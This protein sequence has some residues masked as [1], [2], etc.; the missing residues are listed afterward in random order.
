MWRNFGW[1][2]ILATWT[3]FLILNS[4]LT[5]EWIFNNQINNEY[6]SYKVH[7]GSASST[8]DRKA[9]Y[10]SK[11]NSKSNDRLSMH[12][13][14]VFSEFKN[15]ENRDL[16]LSGY[17]KRD[18]TNAKA[19]ATPSL[20]V[21]PSH[22]LKSTLRKKRRKEKTTYTFSSD[23][24]KAAKLRRDIRA[25][26]KKSE[27]HRK[28]HKRERIFSRENTKT[29]FFSD[30]F[31]KR[32]CNGSSTREFKNSDISKLK[33]IENTKFRRTDEKRE[34]NRNDEDSRQSLTK[35]GTNKLM[36]VNVEAN[37][38]SRILE[39]TFPNY[40][41]LKGNQSLG[42][43]GTVVTDNTVTKNSPYKHSVTV[44]WTTLIFNSKISKTNKGVYNE[45]NT[46]NPY[47][48]PQNEYS[49]SYKRDEF[50]ASETYKRH[51][52]S[53]IGFKVN[54]DAREDRKGNDEDIVDSFASHEPN[55]L[56]RH[57]AREGSFMEDFPLQKEKNAV[58]VAQET[59]GSRREY[60]SFI[61]NIGARI[62]RKA[63][64]LNE[65]QIRRRMREREITAGANYMT[66]NELEIKRD[67]LPTN[68]FITGISGS[69]LEYPT[70]ARISITRKRNPMHVGYVRSGSDCKHSRMTDFEAQVSSA[71]RF[72][73]WNVSGSS[74]LAK[75]DKPLDREAHSRVKYSRKFD[76]INIDARPP[77]ITKII[78]GR[79]KLDEELRRT[80]TENE[81][82][83]PSAPNIGDNL[84][85]MRVINGYEQSSSEPTDESGL[86]NVRDGNHSDM[87]E[88]SGFYSRSSGI[89]NSKYRRYKRHEVRNTLGNPTSTEL[90]SET[91][92]TFD[93]IRPTTSNV[94]IKF[95]PNPSVSVTQTT[96]TDQ[97][98]N[99][100]FLT[101]VKTL[102]SSGYRKI[103]KKWQSI[104]SMTTD[105]EVQHTNAS[106]GIGSNGSDSLETM[107]VDIPKTFNVSSIDTSAFL[108]KTLDRSTAIN[109]TDNS[110]ILK[111][112]SST[113]E[114]NLQISY[115]TNENVFDTSLIE[116][117]NSQEDYGMH[118]N[119][120]IVD[121]TI[122]PF[123][124]RSIN[125]PRN[126]LEDM[127]I[128]NVDDSS[129]DDALSD[130]W[131][132]KHSAVVEGDLVLGGLMMVHEREDTITCGPVMPQG[133][134]QALEAMLYTLDKL[135]D[136]EIV[137]GV[138]I[139]AHI[140]DDC[141]KDTYGLEMAV[142]FIKA[143]LDF[144]DHPSR[145]E[146][147]ATSDGHSRV[148]VFNCTKPWESLS[149]C[150]RTSAHLQFLDHATWRFVTE[151]FKLA[152]CTI[153]PAGSKLERRIKIFDSGRRKSAGVE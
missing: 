87:R 109:K 23:R 10:D 34:Y 30:K 128:E 45:E 56:D 38:E 147:F 12:M 41:S 146:K 46:I 124:Q 9:I 2:A 96:N 83:F 89:H 77:H 145:S 101:T 62:N 7:Q 24:K 106:A 67:L 118:G 120:T 115:A 31:R 47:H 129:T 103:S 29:A 80:S 58:K 82:I 28:K 130:Q 72:G 121:P 110:V 16:R 66:R 113:P 73:L 135:N 40:S 143:D 95:T 122:E 6:T 105:Y 142:D 18:T 74:R 98:P 55:S 14:T 75:F 88:E 137:P 37:D 119:G 97:I 52:Y 134:I 151:Q 149:T 44:A 22:E 11:K 19:K 17:E 114:M 92:K 50:P 108:I 85:E 64:D 117:I 132:V 43:V 93:T 33:T 68:L 141:D 54:T 35:N 69:K 27:W 99:A 102:P 150:D 13:K 104:P 32:S 86:E 49:K 78:D 5:G 57:S 100:N 63:T 70:S 61:S 136:R 51:Q 84:T 26:D 152:A 91:W 42:N 15:M 139:G 153:P 48:S 36:Y 4:G 76:A 59:P 20:H 71:F 79:S 65:L 8:F 144:S 39:T 25:F 138:K 131:P 3:I 116:P 127:T 1:A 148:E 140:L 53:K 107:L 21:S 94:L 133:G 126:V 123:P 112:I 125:S 81:S 111:E 60:H 90:D